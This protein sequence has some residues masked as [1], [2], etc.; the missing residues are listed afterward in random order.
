MASGAEVTSGGLL[1]VGL[2][3]FGA[4]GVVSDAT[5]DSGGLI[6]RL[7]GTDFGAS[8]SGTLQIFSSGL[9]SGVEVRSGGLLQVGLAG[10]AAGG[11]VSDVTIDSGGF[12]FVN[13]GGTDFGASVSGTLQVFSN[14][15]ASGVEV[16]SGGLLQVGLAGF[17]AGGVSDATIDSGGFESVNSGGTDLSNEILGGEQEVYGYASS[18]IIFGGSQV[19]AA[20]GLADT[21]VMSDGLLYVASGGTAS[22]TIMTSVALLTLRVAAKILTSLLAAAT[23][24]TKRVALTSTRWSRVV[25]S[26]SCQ[27]GGIADNTTIDSGGLKLSKQE[28]PPI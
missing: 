15:L 23:N 25:A 6:R 13:S 11:V 7:G 3:G 26:I 17:A 12:E 10:F 16:R 22:G 1:Q 14:G 27:A 4:G 8:V 18:A 9:A 24:S 2:A 19:V 20:D 5:I 28:A 21:N